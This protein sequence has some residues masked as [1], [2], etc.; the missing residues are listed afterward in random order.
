M[1]KAAADFTMDSRR[2]DG[3]RSYC[4][5]CESASKSTQRAAKSEAISHSNRRYWKKNAGRI[6]RRRRIRYA[7]VIHAGTLPDWRI[8]QRLNLAPV[9]VRE[10]A[11]RL[12]ISLATRNL[13]WM[14]ENDEQLIELHRQGLTQKKIAQA[15]GRTTGAVRLQIRKLR[16]AGRIPQSQ[17]EERICHSN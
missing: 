14:P 12:G 5:A 4:K 1:D 8:G 9:T 7:I 6:N 16:A 13:R 10:H 2:K 3:L 15:T 17:T 11:Q